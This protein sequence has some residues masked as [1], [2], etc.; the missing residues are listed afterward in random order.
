VLNGDNEVFDEFSPGVGEPS[1]MFSRF[2]NHFTTWSS[3]IN[4]IEEPA[5]VLAAPGYDSYYHWLL[6]ILPRIHLL[7]SVQPL[8]EHYIIPKNAGE[9]FVASL[10][11]LGIDE[12]HLYPIGHGE[13]VQCSQLFVP[14]IPS[15]E[16]AIPH[17][18][19]D[20]LR[21][22]FLDESYAPE[23][24]K[25]LYVVRGNRRRRVLNEDLVVSA[26]SKLGFEPV[27]GE[28]LSVSQQAR[29]FSEAS[30]II[31]AHGA[32]LTNIV[33][34]EGAKVVEIFRPSVMPL[35]CY[36]PLSVVS[37]NKY[38]G[39]ISEGDESDCGDV[40][41]NIDQ[42]IRTIEFVESQ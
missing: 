17:W 3:Q 11:T 21:R 8:L 39:M 5:A 7:Q 25:K 26:V 19:I 34:A 36:F 22:Q 12:K 4:K 30:M 18:V 41:I 40:I 31:G 33:F 37:N 38:W 9:K 29:I 42:L 16:G 23:R 27:A 2:A 32:G 13:K 35:N 6:Q 10:K 20:F 24:K 15:N 28:N 1:C 14:S